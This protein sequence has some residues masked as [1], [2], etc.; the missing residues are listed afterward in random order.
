MSPTPPER[1]NRGTSKRGGGRV[2]EGRAS[3]TTGRSMRWV[4][5]SHKGG[6]VNDKGYGPCRSETVSRTTK[7]E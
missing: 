1:L 4:C 6:N 7:D 3:G 5:G 2:D